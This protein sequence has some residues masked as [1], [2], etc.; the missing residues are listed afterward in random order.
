MRFTETP[1]HFFQCT[2]PIPKGEEIW[3]P[4][5]KLPLEA[6]NWGYLRC[7]DI[8]AEDEI[9]I[10]N[11]RGEYG[12]ITGIS[13][14]GKV[15]GK[16]WRIRKHTAGGGYSKLVYECFNGKVQNNKQVLHINYNPYDSRPENICVVSH[17]T[18]QERGRR[19][20]YREKFIRN[21]LIEMVK[22]EKYFTPESDMVE[23][24]KVI[25]IPSM[26]LKRYEQYKEKGIVRFSTVK[27]F[28][29][30]ETLTDYYDI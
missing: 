21:T 6:N 15:E 5:P 3:M 20:M 10:R 4:H 28:T 8:E 2:Y 27:D 22:R 13:I 11:Q 24:F 23:Y 16:P 18:I 14:N 12:Q 25:G 29:P 1:Q 7:T 19:Q 9:Y 17:L 30:E 26:I